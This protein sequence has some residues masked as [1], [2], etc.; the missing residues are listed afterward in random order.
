MRARTGPC[1]CVPGSAASTRT[2][3]RWRARCWRTTTRR[4]SDKQVKDGKEIT[5]LRRNAGELRN[6]GVNSGSDL[7]QKKS[8]QL[9]KRAEWLEATLRPGAYASGRRDPP[10]QPRHARQDPG[11][12]PRCAG[13]PRPDGAK[14]FRIA[15]L[16]IRQG[17]RLVLLGR[18]GVG[19]SQLIRLLR[20]AVS[21]TVPGMPAQSEPRPRLH[22]PG[23]GEPAGRPDA[24]PVHRRRGRGSADAQATRLL[25]GAALDVDAQARPIGRCRRVRKPGWACWRCGWREPNFYLLDEPTNHIDIPGQEQLEARAAGAGGDLR[26]GFARPELRGRRGKPV[27]AHRRRS[28]TRGRGSGLIEPLRTDLSFGGAGARGERAWRAPALAPR[29]APPEPACGRGRFSW[30]SPSGWR[31]M[32]VQPSGSR[33][34]APTW[35]GKRPA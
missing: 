14:L 28:G 3:I 32:S 5:R 21:E 13:R 9:R 35:R 25:A 6:I 24:A 1:S 11:G 19:K 18:N 7:L 2:P 34:A 27:P 12:D 16:D 31:R 30:P 15:K 23:H 29:Q 4:R 22:R 8:M 26:A 33:A 17:D 20:R 10:G